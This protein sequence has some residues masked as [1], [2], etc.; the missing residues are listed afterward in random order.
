MDKMMK[1]VIK[2]KPE[3]GALLLTKRPIPHYGAND[4]LVKVKAAAL[5][6]T[7]V[8]IMEWNEWSQ[9]RITPPSIIGHE[10]AG[11]VVAIGDHV[12]TIK[13]GDLISAET[14]IVCN[15]CTLCHNGYEHVCANTKTIGVS[16][17]GC[18]AEYI[19]IP[20]ENAIVYAPSTPAQIVAIM[21]PFGVAV[22]AALEFPIAGK[23]VLVNG[24]GPIGVM[25]IAVAK[26]CGAAKVFAVETNK[27]RAALALM[28]GADEVL[29]PMEVDVV[30]AIKDK[31][32]YGAEVVLEFTG[33]AKAIK[34]AIACMAPEGKM[35]AAGLPDGTVDFDFSEFVYSGKVIKG[36]AGRLMYKTW[37]DAKGLI[38]SGLDLWPIITH[39]LPLEE[40]QEGLRLMKSGECC[41]VI[42]LP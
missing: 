18:F 20:A 24:C 13:V 22:H 34:T 25:A 15:T 3:V 14:H 32:E 33:N 19:A 5:C 30:R 27:Q 6:G 9:K 29:N 11:E 10:F 2:E 39:T 7:D 4:I 26:K 35:A 17:D 28:M 41:K 37:E 38:A 31:T 21:E 12:T 40:Y 42:L 1:C 36:I 16:R 23:A 8:H